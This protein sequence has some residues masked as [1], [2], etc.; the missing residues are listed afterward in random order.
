MNDRNTYDRKL[1]RAALAIQSQLPQQG[2]LPEDLCLPEQYWNQVKRLRRKIARARERGWHRAAES[3]FGGLA[4]AWRSLQRELEEARCALARRTQPRH[5]TSASA[6]YLDLRALESEFDEIEIDLKTHEL[7]V[8]TDAIELDGINLGE[9]QIRLHWTAI[10]DDWPPYRVVALHPHPAARNDNVT[11]PHVEDELLCEG[12]GRSAI[13]AAVA[14]R[15]FYD[16]FLLVN[17]VLHTYGR[18]HAYL[19]LANWDGVPCKDCG[20]SVSDEDCCRCN[21]CDSALC[22]ECSSSCQGCD[23]SHCSRCLRPCA[24]CGRQFCSRCLETCSVCRKRFCKGCREGRTC[25]A[26]YQKLHPKEP[27]NGPSDEPPCEAACLVSQ[28]G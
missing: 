4:D 22:D 11:H 24:A 20:A 9:F 6:I 13:A 12:E 23:N 17:Q 10:G 28:S 15:R 27:E 26:C 14:E 3:L 16:F 19:E 25:N 5:P 1:F 8:T 18:G 2:P 7:A 21:G